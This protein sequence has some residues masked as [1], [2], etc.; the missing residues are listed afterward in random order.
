MF[1]EWL[2]LTG[3][4]SWSE[5]MPN[6]FKLKVEITYCVNTTCTMYHNWLQA[7]YGHALS[8]ASIH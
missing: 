6:P 4:A 1:R 2:G 5:A 3:I 8:R 7:L